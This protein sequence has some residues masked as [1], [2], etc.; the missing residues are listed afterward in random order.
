MP[1]NGSYG[2]S[3]NTPLKQKHLAELMHAMFPAIRSIMKRQDW[4]LKDWATYI[5]MTAGP[6]YYPEFNLRGS[7]LI[8]ID[9]AYETGLA[10]NSWLFEQDAQTYEHLLENLEARTGLFLE[11]SDDSIRRAFLCDGRQKDPSEM[12][13]TVMNQSYEIGLPHVLAVERQQQ[14]KGYNK[15]RYRFG[16]LYLDENG[17]VPPIGY[18]QAI[19]GV[20]PRI[21]LV[22]QLATTT[23]KRRLHSAVD[24]WP[25]SLAEVIDMIGKDYWIVRE[26]F[27]KHNW[28]FLVGTNWDSFPELRSQGFRRTNTPDGQELL[29][30]LDQTRREGVNAHSHD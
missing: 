13:I 20:L 11:R 17:K 16:M 12:G 14:G 27:G 3:E 7:P 15:K 8:A 25:Y 23:I 30:Y 10:L 6:G 2:F 24:P 19:A 21:D 22:I 29:R 18:L 26:P 4:A 9:T 1:I 28:S 5:D